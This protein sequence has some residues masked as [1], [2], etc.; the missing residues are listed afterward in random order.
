MNV[1]SLSK[2][3]LILDTSDIFLWKQ[4]SM[5][6]SGQIFKNVTEKISKPTFRIGSCDNVQ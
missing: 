2:S 6:K 3:S 5:E 1:E 4:F